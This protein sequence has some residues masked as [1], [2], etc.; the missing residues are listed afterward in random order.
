MIPRLFAFLCCLAPL[1][2]GP[3]ALQAQDFPN[4]NIRI[5]VPFAAGGGVDVVARTLARHLSDKLGQQV[6]VENRPG[7]SGNLGADQVAKAPADGYALLISASTLVV[8][9]VVAAEKAPFDPLKDFTQLALIAKGPLLF[10][11]NPDSAATLPEFV[12]R[13]KADPAKFNLATGGFGS[14][15]HRSAEAFKL[16]AGLNV[17]V[18]LYRGTGPAF[19]DV[20][21][22]HISGLMDPLVTSLP[23]AKSGKTRALAISD[24]KR[25]PLAPD[26]PTFAEAGYPGFEFFTWYGLWGPPNL[27][28]PVLAKLSSAIQ[29]IGRV[30]EV[31][32]WF[33][34][35]GLEFSG[36]GGQAFVDFSRAEQARY[37]EIVKKGNIQKQ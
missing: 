28:A 35:Q 18:V 36:I 15:G 2:A 29:E 12:S 10:I 1:L 16:Q 17:P 13:A 9:P 22:G 6:F 24:S 33:E 23:L 14:A 34:A 25:S 3:S 5:V 4:R 30:P 7:A 32:Q 20:V 27:P 37:D 8:N 31:K 21:G 19:N 11:V 26:V